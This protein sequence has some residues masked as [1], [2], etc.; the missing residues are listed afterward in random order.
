ME[1]AE[2]YIVAVARMEAEASIAAEA[3]Y[4]GAVQEVA[5]SVPEGQGW[6]GPEGQGWPG[7]E[8]RAEEYPA[9]VAYLEAAVHLAV[10]LAVSVVVRVDEAP[11]V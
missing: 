2:E 11:A 4:P 7:P 6:P 5:V 3:E 10:A 8:A 9:E 1:V